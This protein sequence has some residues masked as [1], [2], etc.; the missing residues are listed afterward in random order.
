M[1]YETWREPGKTGRAYY[2]FFGL[3]NTKEIEEA[4]RLVASD[5]KI[6]IKHISSVFAWIKGTDL[7]IGN[8]PVVGAKKAIAFYR[9]VK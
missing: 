9:R 3:K 6:S 2:V 1:K 8:G 4:A 5:R 7:Y